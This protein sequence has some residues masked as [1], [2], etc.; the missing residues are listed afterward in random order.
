MNKIRQIAIY[1]KGGIG[2]STISSNL[3]AA[4]SILNK[5]PAQIGCDPKAD[6]VN[7]LT[8]GV[9]IPAISEI[10]RDSGDSESNIFASVKRGFNN[11]A[12]IESGGPIPGQG[13]A[14]RGVLVALNLIDKYKILNKLDVD[15]AVYD[16]LGDIVCGGFAQPVRHGYAEEI[17]IVTSG[18]YMALYAANNIAMSIQHFASQG[19]KARI[20]GIIGNIRNV[21]NEKDIINEFAQLIKLPVIH[22]VPRSELVQRS[23]LAGKTVVEAYPNSDQANSFFDLANKILDNPDRLIPEALTKQELVSLLRKYSLDKTPCR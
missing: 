7:T 20:A 11:I 18:E 17:Y 14:G 10:M 9:F 4:L 16:V 3:T 13:C 12:C 23:E 19:L 22:F 6:S 1:G 5:K 15:F 8:G 21:E 2:K